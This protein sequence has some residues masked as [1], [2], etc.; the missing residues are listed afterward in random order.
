MSGLPSYQVIRSKKRRR[1]MSLR[2]KEDGKIVI[3]VPYRTTR[4]EI[5]R[6]IDKS[7]SWISKKL[8]ER[9]Q[10]IRETKRGFAPSERF[11][12]LGKSYPLSI[13][14]NGNK[15]LP[16]KLS[17]GK[18]VLDEDRVIEARDLFAQWYKAEAKVMLK[19]RVDYYSHRLLLFPKAVRIT[20]ARIHWGSCSGD[21]R[22]SFSW[23]IMMAPLEIV[24]YVLIHELVHIR[25]K[26]H[27]KRF[28]RYLESIVPDYKERRTWLKENGYSLCL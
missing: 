15:Q 17:F 8:S 7:R 4:E 19:E 18:F 9:E 13:E 10:S 14:P 16:L 2:I 21:N 20:S 6:F 11:F 12:Y 5:E 3:Y 23:R 28:W 27:S 25:E 24:D 22:L 26:N 1:T